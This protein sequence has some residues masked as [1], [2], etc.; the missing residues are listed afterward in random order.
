[1]E[2]AAC[3]DVV[4][5]MF[6]NNKAT[7]R[8]LCCDDDSSVQ[9]DCQ[10]SNKDYMKNNGVDTVPIMVE[11]KVGINKGQLQPRPDKG[12]LPGNVPEPLFVA[13]P[14]HRRKGLTGELIKLDT[15]RMEVKMTMTCMD[16][17][18]IGKNFGYMARTL[19][20]KEESEFAD[21]ATAVL[22]HHFDSH[23]YCGAW[24]RRKDET[25]E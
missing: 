1:M 9:A 8:K 19:Q 7:I 6:N 14:N 10:W 22:E 4:V 20:D 24:C 18:R 11:K 13:D 12:K 17:V 16:S 25:I 23:E 3:L 2:A 15:S 21:A 5:N